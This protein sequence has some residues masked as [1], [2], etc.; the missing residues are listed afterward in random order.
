[1]KAT[2]RK[3]NVVKEINNILTRI[4]RGCEALPHECK[5]LVGTPDQIVLP[6]LRAKQLISRSAIAPFQI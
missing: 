2:L 4:P 5:A 1:M 6:K 3:S